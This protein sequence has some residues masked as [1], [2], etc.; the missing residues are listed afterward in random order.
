MLK[1]SAIMLNYAQVRWENYY[2]QN[3]ASIMC[4]GLIHTLHVG[5]YWYHLPFWWWVLESIT[6]SFTSTSNLWT[7]FMVEQI[8][9]SYYPLAESTC[10]QHPNPLITRW[11]RAPIPFWHMIE[12]SKEMFAWHMPL[13]Q[14]IQSLHVHEGELVSH[15]KSTTYLLPLLLLTS[16]TPS[17]A[18]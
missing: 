4:Q 16:N 9:S 8:G 13:A 1:R 7:W 5:I 15:P 18:R 17:L 3:Y 14:R 2:A 6:I 11:K 12:H 10:V